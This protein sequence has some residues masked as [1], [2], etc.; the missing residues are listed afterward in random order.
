MEDN[1]V[2]TEKKYDNNLFEVPRKNKTGIK[3]I[4]ALLFITVAISL[5]VVVIV[6]SK[7]VNTVDKISVD[8]ITY[9]DRPEKNNVDSIH[10]SLLDWNQ[11]YSSN[12]TEVTL[13]NY[14]GISAIKPDTTITDEELQ[15][16][17]MSFTQYYSNMMPITDREIVM[18]GDLVLID[19]LGTVKGVEFEGGTATNYELEIGSNM[20]V[21]DFETQLIGKKVGEKV[22]V[23]VTFPED[24][25]NNEV[26]GLEAEF[27]V[28]INAIGIREFTDAFVAYNTEYETTKEYQ[29]YLLEGLQESKEYNAQSEIEESI[30]TAIIDASTFYNISESEIDAKREEILNTYE[31]HASYYEVDLETYASSIF[32]LTLDEFYAEVDYLA[33]LYV[34]ETYVLAKIAQQ[35]QFVLTGEEYTKRLHEI[36]VTY[37]YKTEGEIEAAYGGKEGLSKVFIEEMV[38][39]FLIEKAVFE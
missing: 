32:G 25:T 8:K 6:Q 5:A 14:I 24:Y 18:N 28:T 17:V 30:L 34:K 4:I 7:A 11:E 33:D 39:D 36:M 19:F 31:S 1:Q 38:L 13:G 35:E 37:D 22:V 3:I 21:G 27:H 26:A 15:E 10:N 2:S 23:T 20:F 29:D 16:E 12:E 9:N